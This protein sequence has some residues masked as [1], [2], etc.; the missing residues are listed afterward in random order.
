[1]A[2]AGRPVGEKV[3]VVVNPKFRAESESWRDIRKEELSSTLLEV[4]KGEKNPQTNTGY[5]QPYIQIN[6]HPPKYRN[7][8]AADVPR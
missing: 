6:P 5:P 1:V 4:V 8:E 2:A 7:G 3:V